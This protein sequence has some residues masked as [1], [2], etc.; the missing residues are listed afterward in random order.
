MS[1]TKYGL[2]LAKRVFQ[3]YW[4]D[5]NPPSSRTGVSVAMS[6]SS[7][8]VVARRVESRSRPVGV[9]TGGLG[10]SRQQPKSAY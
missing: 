2:D 7:S 3:L 10:R 4:I 1:D 6:C 5:G 9:R 8:S